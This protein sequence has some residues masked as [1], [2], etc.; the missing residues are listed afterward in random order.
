MKLEKQQRLPSAPTTQGLPD[1]QAVQPFH[2]CLRGFS[3]PSHQADRHGDGQKLMR[4]LSQTEDQSSCLC[5]RRP[6]RKTQPYAVDDVDSGA[7]RVSS[8]LRLMPWSMRNPGPQRRLSSCSPLRFVDSAFHLDGGLVA[9][10]DGASLGRETWI[11]PRSSAGAHDGHSGL[12][13][14]ES[15]LLPA[16]FALPERPLHSGLP[17]NFSNS[18]APPGPL[19]PKVVPVFAPLLSLSQG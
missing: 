16:F 9:P 4:V 11:G 18:V 10:F 19:L 12:V 7:C 17:L 2:D 5:R 13:A 8:V 3:V 15:A 1:A 6:Q 14:A